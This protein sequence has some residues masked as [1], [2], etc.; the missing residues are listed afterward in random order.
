MAP[1]AQVCYRELAGM[2]EGRDHPPSVIRVGWC[3]TTRYPD[4]LRPRD[5]Q[6]AQGA[7]HRA[8]LRS[9]A[10]AAE[11]GDG[12]GR[13]RLLEAT[14]WDRLHSGA[15]GVPTRA[16]VRIGAGVIGPL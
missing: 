11:T 10:G 8:D 2:G 7:W 16:H 12:F 15:R 14:A 5:P 9:P 1:A 13:I 3:V 4:L 6:S